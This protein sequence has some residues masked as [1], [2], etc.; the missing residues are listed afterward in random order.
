MSNIYII[1]EA[2]VNHNGQL[3]L[4]LEM[5][6]VAKSAG[7]NAVKF[8]TWKTKNIVTKSAKLAKYQESEKQLG[9]ESQYDMLEKL[10]LSF[11]DFST[12]RDHCNQIGITFLSTPDDSE[13]LSFLVELGMDFI[14][15]GSGEVNNIPFLREI[16]SKQLPVVL[17]TGMSNLGEV[18][19]AYN[20]LVESGSKD[21]TLLHCTTNY[22]CPMTEVNLMAMQTLSAAFNC[23]TGYSDH[24]EGIEVPI[25]AAALG[26][27]IIEKHFT[28]DKSMKGPDHKASVDPAE[29]EQMINSI[30]NIEICLGDGIKKPNRSELVIQ[31]IVKKKIVASRMIATGEI[32]SD[33]NLT[34]KRTDYGIPADYW[35]YLQGL[36]SNRNYKVDDAVVIPVSLLLR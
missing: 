33:L 5:C 31:N 28:L 26:A 23:P 9:N 6:N 14:K 15:I 10:E 32:F 35:D 22:P 13:S 29:L 24:T 20:V 19:R 2:G 16:G 3:D 27:R 34:V 12:I 25:A 11:D 17:S 18:E 4:A 21:I 1:A 8:Q 30:R 36:E 7:A